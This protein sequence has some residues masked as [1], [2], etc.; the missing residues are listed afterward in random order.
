MIQPIK[1]RYE[2]AGLLGIIIGVLIVIIL[3]FIMVIF[4]SNSFI[5]ECGYDARW[6]KLFEKHC[7]TVYGGDMYCYEDVEAAQKH[8]NAEIE[9]TQKIIELR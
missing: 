1:H 3:M 5:Q 6:E 2:A 4:I 8:C 9:K 7:I